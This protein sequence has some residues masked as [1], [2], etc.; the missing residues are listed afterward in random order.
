MVM[1]SNILKLK[2]QILKL[3]ANIENHVGT[4]GII[5]YVFI[6]GKSRTLF[7]N[8]DA[9]LVLDKKEEK[10]RANYELKTLCRVDREQ[11]FYVVRLIY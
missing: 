11:M 5:R 6:K 4:K 3:H 1:Q 10:S 7:S 2:S 9:W 8:A